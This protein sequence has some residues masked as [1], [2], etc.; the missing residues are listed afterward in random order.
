MG[1]RTC[2]GWRGEGS[3]QGLGFSSRP[4][5]RKTWRRFSNAYAHRTH[6]DKT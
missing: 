2:E 3:A 4:R 1:I 6:S 5:I